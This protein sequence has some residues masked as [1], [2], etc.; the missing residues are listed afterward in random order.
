MLAGMPKVPYHLKKFM[1]VAFSKSQLEK[2]SQ[3]L[4]EAERKHIPDSF[5]EMI[6]TYFDDGWIHAEA[7]DYD[8]RNRLRVKSLRPA[9]S[10]PIR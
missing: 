8:V 4:T 3:Q 2:L 6:I 10:S 9:K 7:G 1:E 5:D